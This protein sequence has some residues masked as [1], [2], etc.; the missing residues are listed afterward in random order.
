MCNGVITITAIITECASASAVVPADTPVFP[1][2]TSA[3]RDQCV[4]ERTAAS[5]ADAD[6]AD[7]TS[8]ATRSGSG[9]MNTPTT[10][11]A[12][13]MATTLNTNGAASLGMPSA[14]ETDP[15]GPAR[16]GP[17]TAPMVVAQTTSDRERARCA[18]FARSVAA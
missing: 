4:P 12:T 2:I 9:L 8:R 13:T 10:T 7:A 17:A 11:A 14:T 1:R 3:T 5:V 18:G 16:F 15:A 6:C